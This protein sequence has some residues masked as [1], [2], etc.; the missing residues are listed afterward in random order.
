ML[1]AN[2]AIMRTA[3]IAIPVFI[4]SFCFSDI[5]SLKKVLFI[6]FVN[7][8]IYAPLRHCTEA[9]GVKV[10]PAFNM[11]PI[12]LTSPPAGIVEL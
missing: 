1:T 6:Q 8:P 2:I 4:R 7:F 5:F 9:D 12:S 3:I 11:T 10:L